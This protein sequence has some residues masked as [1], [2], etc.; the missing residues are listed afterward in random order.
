MTSCSIFS[1]FGEFSLCRQYFDYEP[2][3]LAPMPLKPV[4]S[5]AR[6]QNLLGV[7]SRPHSDHRGPVSAQ[8]YLKNWCCGHYNPSEKHRKAPINQK[9]SDF[10]EQFCFATLL[11]PNACFGG[12]GRPESDLKISGENEMAR[13]KNKDIDSS[14]RTVPEHLSKLG[15]KML[16]KSTKNQIWA[17]GSSRPPTGCKVP[18]WRHQACQ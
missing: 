18:K 16:P 2:S 9:S 10:C 15:S 6:T 12:P 8:V 11:T 14:T 1:Y 17:L 3:L 5:N 4:N 13:S 7:L